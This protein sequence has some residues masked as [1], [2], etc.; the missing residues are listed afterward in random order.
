MQQDLHLLEDGL[1]VQ[2]RVSL[3]ANANIEK[4]EVTRFIWG[5]K[6]IPPGAQQPKGSL[7]VY[8]LNKPGVSSL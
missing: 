4:L 3:D 2:F 1:L 7:C 6:K 8:V 5:K